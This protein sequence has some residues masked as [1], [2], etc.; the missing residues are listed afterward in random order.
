MGLGVTPCNHT[1]YNHITTVV[2]NHGIHL[3]THV[4]VPLSLMSYFT[5]IIHIVTVIALL[6]HMYRTDYVE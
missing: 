1:L 6:L 2:V 3:K 5:C 4:V